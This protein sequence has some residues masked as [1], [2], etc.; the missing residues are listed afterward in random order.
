MHLTTR[1][2]FLRPELKLIGRAIACCLLVLFSGFAVAA[3][4]PALG[5]A[6]SAG[7]AKA[8]TLLVRTSDHDRLRPVPMLFT[9]VQIQVT[10]MIGRSTVTQHFSNPTDQW[11]EGVYIFPL[12][13]DAAVDTLKMQIGERLIVGEIEERA[14]ARKIYQKAKSQG[15]KTTLLE[16]ERPNIFTTSVAN[17]GPGETIEVTI[18]YQQALRYDNG[19]FSLR[20]PMVVAPRYIPGAT[21]ISAFTGSG[22][23]EDTD[24]VPDASRVTPRVAEPGNSPINP[25]RIRARIEA[26]FPL[27]IESP[28]HDI[29]TSVDGE[30]SEVV[31]VGNT[32]PADSDF[33][34]QWRPKVGDAPAAAL[35]SDVYQGE[36]YALLMVMP[37]SEHG[38]EV[39]RL[40]R[41][42]VF[43]IDTSGSMDGRSIIQAQAA[44]QLAL[45]RL[46]PGDSFN[47]IQFNS[48][49]HK[50]FGSSRPATTNNI[51]A[52]VRYV[53]DLRATGGTEMLP[54]LRLALGLTGD[55]GKVRQVIFITDG[56]V[57]N[58][59]ALLAYIRHNI[60]D[61]R[62]FTVGIGSS[63]NGHFM[64]KAAGHGRGTYTYIGQTGEVQAKMGTLFAKLENPLL[65]RIDI[66]W[67]GQPVEHW[68]RHLPDLYLGEPVVIT[69]RVPRLGSTVEIS[70]QRSGRPWAVSFTLAG[71]SS[72][73]GI[74]RLFARRKIEAL[75]D[76]L[77]GEAR[78]EQVRKD[79]VELGLAHHLVTRHTSLVAVETIASR[80]QDDDLASSAL[81]TNL[82][83]GWVHDSVF[84]KEAKTRVEK[85]RK[86]KSADAEMKRSA[87]EEKRKLMAEHQ[88]QGPLTLKVTQNRA[89]KKTEASRSVDGVSL[90]LAPSDEHTAR[91]IP[92]LATSFGSAS[93]NNVQR[94]V[95]GGS[96][97]R[98]TT[99]QGPGALPQTAT[100]AAL[101]LVLGLSLLV[102][103][104]GFRQRRARPVAGRAS[105]E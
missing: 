83:K 19:A 57:G 87:E 15:K 50:L 10:G 91:A 71:G 20:F 96:T 53:R 4:S 1:P 89:A 26:G 98:Y 41:E 25:V 58:E 56:S 6:M 104:V 100:A 48:T 61:S 17:I 27:T 43:V 79:I 66:D 80:P 3:Q 42:T 49:P 84:G 14:Q 35:F 63:P 29:Q 24:Q 74:D 33:V 44:L 7:D 32:V 31:L 95:A 28:S 18:E 102:L 46:A 60:H 81:P 82:P 21:R 38:A 64:R 101:L 16:Q 86:R 88:R 23:A 51:Q 78:P 99:S 62:L 59:S 22:W 92:M 37:P 67:Q 11:L 73:S 54:A 85:A 70:G 5:R 47:V 34:L 2:D 9:D 30:V 69:A 8:G 97:R 105:M 77:A 36:T 94:L 65:T 72:H 68:P 45:R 103:A 55:P 76:S 90:S 75:T 40:P 12:P 39:Q 13:D 93:S 52:A